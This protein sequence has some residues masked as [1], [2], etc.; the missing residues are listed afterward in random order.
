MVGFKLSW[1]S[2]QQITGGG[3]QSEMFRDGKNLH[4][5]LERTAN[6]HGPPSNAQQTLMAQPHYAVKVMTHI[7]D[8]E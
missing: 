6:F 3:G 8:I 5:T 2:C 7:F 4:A 1:G